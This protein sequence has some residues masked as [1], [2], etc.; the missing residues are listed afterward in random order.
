M[1]L[2][3]E[4]PTNIDGL[5]WAPG[6]YEVQDEYWAQRLLAHG[7]RRWQES[8]APVTESSGTSPGTTSGP[9]RRRGRPRRTHEAGD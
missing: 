8:P 5:L 7:A 9:E 6:D 1:K 3:V 4:Q 2:R